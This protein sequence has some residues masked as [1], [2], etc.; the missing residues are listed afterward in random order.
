MTLLS[1]GRAETLLKA[2]QYPMLRY[3]PYLFQYWKYWAG[4]NMYPQRLYY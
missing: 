3:Y 2:G 1:D 4:Q